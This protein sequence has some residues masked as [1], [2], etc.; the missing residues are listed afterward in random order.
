MKQ[1]RLAFVYQRGSRV[2]L[3]ERCA[4]VLAGCEHIKIDHYNLA[5][6]QDVS[7]RYDYYLRLDDGDYSLK[8]PARLRP[9]AWWIS[10]THLKHCYQKIRVQASGYDALFFAQKDALGQI[11]KDTGKTGYWL[12]WAAD[13]CRGAIDFLPDDQRQR[14]VCFIGTSGKF[15]LR[16]V[17]LET[18]QK[19]Y[20]NAYIGR[21]D[22]TQLP[23]YYS[24]SRIV[25]NYPIRNDVNAR[26]FEAMAA[27]AMVLSSR[28]QGNGIAELF[29]EGKEIAYYEDCVDDLRRQ[30]DYY[31]RNAD[32]RMAIARRGFDLVNGRHTYRHRVREL[33]RTLGIESDHGL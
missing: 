9:A 19:H 17:V 25:V 29:T 12:P 28:V 13:D 21:A 32:Q 8:M 2:A 11:H 24:Q 1:Y 15:S 16:K 10:D 33:L 22:Y 7:G 31:L 18:L 26:F 20:P 30:L 4:A 14:D 27:G 23:R 6:I 5:E 3:G